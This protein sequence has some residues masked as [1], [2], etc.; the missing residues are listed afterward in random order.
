[1]QLIQRNNNT[2][3]AQILPVN[4]NEITTGPMGGC[5]SVIV[6][7]NLNANNV[8]Q[9]AKGYHGGGGLGNVNFNSLFANVP[10]VHTTMIVVASGTLQASQYAQQNNRQTIRQ[11]ANNHGLGNAYIQC[12]HGFGNTRVPRN[13]NITRV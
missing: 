8:Y 3:A 9:S 2:S 12:C 11:E 10:N 13:G 7:Y 5:V 6:L 4:D 1:M